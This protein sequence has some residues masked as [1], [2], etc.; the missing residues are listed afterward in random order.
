MLENLLRRSFI[1]AGLLVIGCAASS[2]IIPRDERELCLA[3]EEKGVEFSI[4]YEGLNKNDLEQIADVK[5]FAQAEF[6]LLPSPNYLTFKDPPRTLHILIVTSST[7]SPLDPYTSADYN[8]VGNHCDL[9]F[10]PLRVVSEVDDLKDEEDCYK[11]KGYDV[12]LRETSNIGNGSNIN[13]TFMRHSWTNRASLIF[14]E[15]LHNT[16]DQNGKGNMD[17][18]LKES[19]AQWVGL[20]GAKEYFRFRG[21]WKN[22]Q[23]AAQ[24]YNRW[25]NYSGQVN[26]AI[27]SI[28]KLHKSNDP[29][30]TEKERKILES[31]SSGMTKPA[32]MGEY[33]YTKYFQIIDQVYVRLNRNHKAMMK[34]ILNAPNNKDEAMSYLQSKLK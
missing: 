12:F 17:T 9:S 3:L 15:D 20:I 11:Q 4:C 34:I 8:T 26:S 28:D 1:W 31:V 30:I 27:E 13:R 2:K 7:S 23:A 22:Y 32:L 14:H 33:P 16:D 5:Q 6:E 24:E 21:D 19:R 18:M 10:P 29:D 25:V